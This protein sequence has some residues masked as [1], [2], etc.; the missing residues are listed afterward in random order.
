MAQINNSV[1]DIFLNQAVTSVT[2]AT[3]TAA[4]TDVL[5]DVNFAGAVT[6][7]LPTGS[8]SNKGKFYVIKDT[9]GA[10]GTHNITVKPNSGTLDG[11]SS[12]IISLNY[13]ALQVYSDGANWWEQANI[14]SSTQTVAQYGVV[15]SITSGSTTSSTSYSA[16][17]GSTF[18][19]P[20]AGVWNIDFFLSVFNGGGDN[21][22]FQLYNVTSSSAVSN[23]IITGGYGQGVASTTMGL[24]GFAQVTTTG[25]TQFQLQWASSNAGNTA[26]I[27]NT[28][29][30][31]TNS[32]GQ[33]TIRYTQIAG[34]I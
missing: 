18:T 13:G 29:T 8:T 27:Y 31:A 14:S 10:A 4:A 17:P 19:I 6:I 28:A 5:I 12:A 33:S 24:S 23:T 25:S 34:L 9:S 2:S 3:Y 22:A 11:A 21:T 15:T 32:G 7:T 16:V 1:N 26:T 30:L 20:S